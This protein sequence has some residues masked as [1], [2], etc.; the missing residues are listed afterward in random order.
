MPYLVALISASDST[1]S[2]FGGFKFC[3]P[4][5][6]R[7]YGMHLAATLKQRGDVCNVAMPG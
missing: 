1:L 6:V 5:V 3:C 4:R 7:G 2:V